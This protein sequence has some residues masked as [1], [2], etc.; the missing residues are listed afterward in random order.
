M[1]VDI[2][3]LG[4]FCCN[5]HALAI[6]WLVV[7]LLR[8]CVSY[9]LKS[10]IQESTDLALSILFS[11]WTRLKRCW[12]FMEGSLKTVTRTLRIRNF[13]VI[14]FSF[15]ILGNIWKWILPY[16]LI[17]LTCGY[18]FIFIR[19]LWLFCCCG[20]YIAVVSMILI[21]EFNKCLFYLWLINTNFIQRGA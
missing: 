16:I 2:S 14:L 1:K 6:S 3:I 7:I 8:F 18:W 20:V 5:S 4:K 11:N 15:C 19:F 12:W 9:E 21:A 17:K 10:L 13:T